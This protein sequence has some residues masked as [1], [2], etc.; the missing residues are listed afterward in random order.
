VNNWLRREALSPIL[1]SRRF[2]SAS[3]RSCAS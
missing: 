1:G 3:P 2:C